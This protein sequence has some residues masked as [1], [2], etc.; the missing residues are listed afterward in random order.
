[1][2]AKIL[3]LCRINKFPLM[4]KEIS[5]GFKVRTK[6]IIH[7][8]SET[9]YIPPLGTLEIIGGLSIQLNL[10]DKLKDRALYLDRKRRQFERYNSYGKSMLCPHKGYG[11]RKVCCPHRKS[12]ISVRHHHCRYTNGSREERIENFLDIYPCIPMSLQYFQNRNQSTFMLRSAPVSD[13]NF[14]LGDE[15]NNVRVTSNIIAQNK[16]K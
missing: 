4:L 2:A 5:R 8:Q 13:D 14:Q 3:W 9:D 12:C 1:M 11:S 16:I 15:L 7:L 6:D 10:P